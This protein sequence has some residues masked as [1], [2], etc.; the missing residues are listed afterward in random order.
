MP[1][2]FVYTYVLS[3]SIDAEGCTA[4]CTCACVSVLA[5]CGVYFIYYIISLYHMFPSPVCISEFV[6][7]C[8][9]VNTPVMTDSLLNVLT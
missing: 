2:D 8:R 6:K 5:I 4:L 1:C 7:R 3:C 9:S